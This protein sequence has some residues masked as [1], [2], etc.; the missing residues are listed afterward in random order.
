MAH[1]LPGAMLGY[2]PS[3]DDE[4][5]RADEPLIELSEKLD[6]HTFSEPMASRSELS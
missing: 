2:L 3:N 1:A 5:N 6:H 4:R